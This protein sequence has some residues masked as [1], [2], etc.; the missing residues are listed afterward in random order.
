MTCQPELC[1]PLRS[2]NVSSQLYF[3]DVLVVKSGTS[4]TQIISES[5]VEATGAHIHN[6]E[7]SKI[8]GTLNGNKKV[9]TYG[10]GP[11]L[12]ERN[13]YIIY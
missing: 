9:C 11:Y 5:H 10:T 7:H 2:V 1:Y 12:F 8:L 13:T 4:T 6:R 3:V